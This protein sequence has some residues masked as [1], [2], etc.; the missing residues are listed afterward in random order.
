MTRNHWSYEPHPLLNA[1][2]RWPVMAAAA[3]ATF[4]AAAAAVAAFV[5]L[6]LVFLERLPR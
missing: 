1:L 5:W 2:W 3:L 4:V 6:V